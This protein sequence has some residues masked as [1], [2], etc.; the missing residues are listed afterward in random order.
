VA[1]AK[2]TREVVK[3]RKVWVD[4]CKDQRDDNLSSTGSQKR[5][6]FCWTLVEVSDYRHQERCVM[7]NG[8]CSGQTVL[9][10]KASHWE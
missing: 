3:C 2:I 9:E 1:R 4:P 7:K 5:R 8:W 6:A 10:K